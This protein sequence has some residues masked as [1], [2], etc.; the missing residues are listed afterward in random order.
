MNMKMYSNI[1]IYIIFKK[2]INKSINIIIY[3]HQYILKEYIFIDIYTD[4]SSMRMI[5]T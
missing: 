2:R 5:R 4:I 3:R 1:Y